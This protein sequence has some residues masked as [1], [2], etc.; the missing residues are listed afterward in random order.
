M[1]TE[2]YQETLSGLTTP[3]PHSVKMLK[4]MLQN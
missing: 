3:P 1:G 4:Q 2:I